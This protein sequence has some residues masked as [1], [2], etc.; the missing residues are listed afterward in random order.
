[1]ISHVSRELVLYFYNKLYTVYNSGIPCTLV[2]KTQKNVPRFYH[3]RIISPI[4]LHETEVCTS[5]LNELI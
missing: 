2:Y 3:S 4:K 1:M 5:W